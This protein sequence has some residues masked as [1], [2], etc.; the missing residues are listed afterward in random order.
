M[1]CRR[2]LP[3]P[4]PPPDD[5]DSIQENDF[6]FD[7]SSYMLFLFMMGS[8]TMNFF[9]YAFMYI[10]TD[11][12]NVYTKLSMGI[13]TQ[14][15]MRNYWMFYSLLA[16]VQIN[17]LE[18]VVSLLYAAYII[19]TPPEYMVYSTVIIQSHV[20]FNI[21]YR[22]FYF[23]MNR[24]VQV[25]FYQFIFLWR[26]FTECLF[27]FLFV[28]YLTFFSP[29]LYTSALILFITTLFRSDILITLIK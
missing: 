4:P 18:G 14:A 5:L 2:F 11:H 24:T 13:Q 6:D 3:P 17:T 7:Y 19:I 15:Y 8:Y 20:I 28:F 1:C 9:W 23:H 26:I 25:W 21:L 27:G 12:T 22:L 29:K 10:L 16:W